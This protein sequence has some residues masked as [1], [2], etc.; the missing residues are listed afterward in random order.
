MDKDKILN[1]TVDL[2]F[3]KVEYLERNH[4][5]KKSLTFLTSFSEKKHPCTRSI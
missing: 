5:F 3:P 1:L 2:T 4:Y